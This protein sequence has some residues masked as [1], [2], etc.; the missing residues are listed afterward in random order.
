M[1]VVEG[2]KYVFWCGMQLSG[3]VVSYGTD[4]VFTVASEGGLVKGFGIGLV[5]AQ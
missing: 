3:C 5:G 1:V 4:G 2:S